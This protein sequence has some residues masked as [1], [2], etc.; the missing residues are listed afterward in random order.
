MNFEMCQVSL[1]H[2]FNV[3]ILFQ[4]YQTAIMSS[5]DPLHIQ[6]VSNL[7]RQIATL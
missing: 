4:Y 3:C 7:V 1:L 2:T 5:N 6:S